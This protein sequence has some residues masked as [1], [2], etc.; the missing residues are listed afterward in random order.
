PTD[1]GTCIR[2]YVHVEDLIQA[3]TKA[4]TYLQNGGESDI[5]NLGSSQ[6]FSVKEMIAAAGKVTGKNIPTQTEPRRKGDPGTLIASSDKARTIHGW[7]TDQ[8]TIDKIMK[9]A[10]NWHQTHTGGYGKGGK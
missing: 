7:Q 1:D 10:W 8:T 6:G 2:D 5:F 9:D 3:H 4:L